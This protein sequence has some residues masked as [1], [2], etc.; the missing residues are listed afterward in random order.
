MGQRVNLPGILPAQG[1]E[2]VA[3]HR[4]AHPLH[5][6]ED[7]AQ[8]HLNVLKQGEQAIFFH[9]AAHTAAQTVQLGRTH[10]LMGQAE[11]LAQFGQAVLG[12]GGA[13]E[14]GGNHSVK[15]S[16]PQGDPL[17]GQSVQPALEVEHILSGR[18]RLQDGLKRLY[19]A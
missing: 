4:K 17:P 5:L 6:I 2:H 15:I 19:R 11:L 14:V 12:T 7:V 18:L 1:P 8:G 16:A 9:P 10:V 3:V 13:Q